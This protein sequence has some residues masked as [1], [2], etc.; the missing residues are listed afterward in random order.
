MLMIELVADRSTRARFGD[1]GNIVQKARKRVFGTRL[2]VTR[3]RSAI[4]ARG[5]ILRE[6]SEGIFIA[7]PLIVSSNDIDELVAVAVGAIADV[8]G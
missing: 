7:P 2:E 8:L 1:G 6:S 5:A 4:R 3:L